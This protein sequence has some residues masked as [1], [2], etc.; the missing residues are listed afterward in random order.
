LKKTQ[1][2]A[3]TE[4][5]GGRP[6][7]A[8][9]ARIRGQILDIAS[10]MFF[11]QG[12]GVVSIE[13][14]AKQAGISKR[15]FYARFRDKAE[16]FSAVVHHLIDDL[17]PKGGPQSLTGKNL[18]ETL[19][20]LALL[21]LHSAL[22]PKTLALQRLMLAEAGRFPELGRVVNEVGARKE[23]IT[24]IAGMLVQDATRHAPKL[25]TEQAMFAA[26]QFI[27]MLTATPLRRAMGL[28][29]P[30]TEAEIETWASRS[31]AMFLHGYRG[32]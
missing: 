31:V 30:M 28:G 15:T 2:K 32:V 26:D 19:H 22:K 3:V 12:Y 5:R 9:A 27:S 21:I 7:Q 23:A 4:R 20:T 29:V 11:S 14:I 25:E 18:E 24:M 17:R 6:S 8:D 13:A 1:S 16:L 10:E